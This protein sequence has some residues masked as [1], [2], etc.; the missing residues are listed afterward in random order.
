MLIGIINT[1][2]SEKHMT[3]VDNVNELKKMFVGIG[4]EDV[5]AAG[6]DFFDVQQTKLITDYVYSR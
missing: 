5:R 2:V 6:L 1:S 3:M 4:I